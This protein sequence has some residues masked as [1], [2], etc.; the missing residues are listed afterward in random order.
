[1]ET[2]VGAVKAIETTEASAGMRERPIRVVLA[3]PGLDGHDRGVR[4]VGRALRDAGMEV[5]YVK[6]VT[7]ADIVSIAVQEDADVV[8][9]S[10][11]SGSHRVLLPQLVELLDEQG[12]GDVVVLGGGIIPADDMPDLRRAGVDAVF[13]PGTMTAEITEAV[14]RLVGERRRG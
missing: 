6:F 10:I 12:L 14:L 5:V 4:L 8:G 2:G 3:K 9:V 11:L 1:M 7:L 13:G